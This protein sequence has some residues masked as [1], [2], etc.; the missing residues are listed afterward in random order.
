M[1]MFG[2]HLGLGLLIVLPIVIFGVLHI[3]NAHDRPNR[4]AVR[5]GYLLF[6]TSLVVLFTGLL[7]TRI[8]IFQ[9]KNVGLKD[10]RL[11]SLAYWAHVITPLAAVWLYILHRLAGP[12]IKWQVG[13]R[14]AGGVAVIVVGMV[15]LPSA[16]PR[17]NQ[18]G[19]VEGRKYFEPSM[20]RTASGNFI[21]ARTLMMDNYCLNC[22]QDGY[23]G[24]FHSSHHFSSFNN[25]PY[26]FS[27]RETRQ[28]ALKRDGNVK[29]ARWCAG[30]H[31]VVPFFSGAFDD[32]NYDLDKDRTY[33]AGITCTTCD[34]MTHA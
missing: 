31:D 11:R 12:R 14:W 26:L 18:T 19:S 27:V 13:L 6:I 3:K 7:L 25:K 17:K 10:P 34:S 32:P 5:V 8:D 4:R 22:H 23:D 21:P 29:A 15:L 24:W 30:C 28:V 1:V 16:H 33:H 2:T 9:F 20:A